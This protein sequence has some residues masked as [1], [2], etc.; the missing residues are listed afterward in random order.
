MEDTD[1]VETQISIHHDGRLSGLIA[2]P[3]VPNIKGL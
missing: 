2:T 3:A 1:E